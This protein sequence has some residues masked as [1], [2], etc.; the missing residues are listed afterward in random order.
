MTCSAGI[1]FL[2]NLI[3]YIRDEPFAAF[4]SI[5]FFDLIGNLALTSVMPYV[6]I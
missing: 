4:K 1:D 6:L 3:R 2:K 5:D